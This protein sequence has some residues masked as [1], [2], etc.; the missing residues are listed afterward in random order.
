MIGI[1]FINRLR[2]TPLLATDAGRA[3]LA[4]N[5][6]AELALAAAVVGIAA[7]LGSISP[8]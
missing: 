2:V 3:T 4:R 1:A 7:V 5:V 8:G 6:R